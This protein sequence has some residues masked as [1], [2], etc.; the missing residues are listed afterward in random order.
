MFIYL[1][2]DDYAVH[3]E[4]HLDRYFIK[5]LLDTFLI[6]ILFGFIF[7]FCLII[8]QIALLIEK[9]IKND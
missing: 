5:Y 6:S 1:I 7:G 4:M 8:D 3:N 2:K 9:T